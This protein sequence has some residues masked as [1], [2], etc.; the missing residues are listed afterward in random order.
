MTK[1]STKLNTWLT[2]THR[3]KMTDNGNKMTKKYQTT[4]TQLAK[5]VSNTEQKQKQ[6]D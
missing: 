4:N 6:N 5:K 1:R 3:H 2:K